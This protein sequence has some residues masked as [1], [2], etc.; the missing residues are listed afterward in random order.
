MSK[1]QCVIM[2]NG[3]SLNDMPQE[4]L[5]Q[6]DSFGVNY[7]KHQPTYY[8]C[9][10][11]EI[12]TQ[13]W[14]RIYSVA[15]AAR[16]VFFS[17][18][19]DGSSMLYELPNVVLVTHDRETFI[20][21]HYFTGLTVTYVAL[22]CAYHMGYEEVHLWGV[23]HSPEWK[24]YKDDYLPGDID[25]RAWRMAEMEYHYQLAQKVYNAAGRRIINHSL[26]S[27]LDAIFER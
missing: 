21:E 2:G 19:H 14:Q 6:M 27:K 17:L 24:H 11:T 22:K 3:A 23:D 15:S 18:K 20:G 25:R 13:H 5:L 16:N 9:V 7:A 12:L 4:L 8:V 10:D 26:P 1:N